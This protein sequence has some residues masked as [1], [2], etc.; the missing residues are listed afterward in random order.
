MEIAAKSLHPRHR[1]RYVDSF[2]ALIAT[3][4]AGDVNALCW[5]R[6]LA[7]DFQEIIDRL[8]AEDGMTT[9]E[10]DDIRA[11]ALGPK[12]AAAREVLLADQVL[13]RNHGLDPSLDCIMGYLRDATEGPVAT[14]VYS[15]HVDRTPVPADTYLCTY[16]GGS[17]EGL[18]N[19]QAVR[20]VDVAET[21]AQLLKIYGGKDDEAF[22]AYLSEHSFDLHYA[23]LPGAQPYA[24]GV[25]NLWRIAIAHPGSPV[26]PCIHRAPLMLPGAAARLLLIS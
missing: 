18:A 4:F 20:R 16:I 26:L 10:D 6:Q 3:P 17:S 15:F 14:D 13:L 8:Q 23:A 2:D 22:D 19:E 11:L 24:F 21:R 5:P 1:V 9:I 12:G 25:G 7:G